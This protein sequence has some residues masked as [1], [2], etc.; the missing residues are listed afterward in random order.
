MSTTPPTESELREEFS[1]L[2]AEHEDLKSDLRLSS[3]ED[4]NI[5]IKIS[6]IVARKQ[7][8]QRILFTGE[9]K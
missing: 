2:D 4:G 6:D 7:E 3:D 9:I 1:R 8:I 5:E